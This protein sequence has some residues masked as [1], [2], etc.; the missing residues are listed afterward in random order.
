M[1][2]WGAGVVHDTKVLAGLCRSRQRKHCA[3]LVLDPNS[4]SD[5]EKECWG[6][7]FVGRDEGF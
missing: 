3:Y 7:R 2:C 5:L 1:G 6:Y 4:V